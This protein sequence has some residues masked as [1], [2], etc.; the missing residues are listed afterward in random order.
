M[1]DD[2]VSR[3][4]EP[5]SQLPGDDDALMERVVSDR[6]EAATALEEARAEIERLR[7]EGLVKD[8]AIIEAAKLAK[9]LMT[10]AVQAEQEHTDM[11][12]QR[13][14][15]EERTE[16]A[17][18]ALAEARKVIEPIVSRL[19]WDGHMQRWALAPDMPAGSITAARRFIASQEPAEQ[20]K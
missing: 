4:R 18:S 5:L 13:R 14:R 8:S 2:L 15:A 1:S 10:R 9:K 6:G 17:E 16:E 11:M 3:L 7:Q 19:E 20:E 12:W